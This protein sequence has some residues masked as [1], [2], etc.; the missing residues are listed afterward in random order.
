MAVL[1]TFMIGSIIFY[2]VALIY[3]GANTSLLALG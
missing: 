3:V 1:R 2:A